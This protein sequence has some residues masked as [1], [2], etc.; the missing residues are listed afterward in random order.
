MHVASQR[1]PLNANA[2]SRAQYAI[3]P[4]GI[5]WPNPACPVALVGMEDGYEE[6]ADQKSKPGTA[7]GAAKSSDR[8]ASSY[9]N[10]PEAKA[11]IQAV[12]ALLKAG[13]VQSAALLTP[14]RGQ[15]RALEHM[16]RTL[17]GHF[18][19][20]DVSVSSVDGYQGREADV[21][22]FTT[23]RCNRRGSIGFVKD[24]RRLNVAI[25]RPRRGL[26]VVGSPSTLRSSPDWAGFVSWAESIG[27]VLPQ[28]S[29]PPPAW[30]LDLTVAVPSSSSEDGRIEELEELQS[31]VAMR[32]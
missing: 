21:V 25:T 16:L 1:L 32:Q 20:M 19:G 31:R 11:A 18:Q 12:H 9:K 24:P 29:L 14:Y 3:S 2:I 13:D 10:I 23:V 6:K 27:A 26:V 8:E 28:S 7:S 17:S 5:R 4:Q 30:D 15:V 22:V